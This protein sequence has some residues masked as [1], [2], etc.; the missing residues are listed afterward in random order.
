MISIT[1]LISIMERV[2][3][4]IS[5]GVEEEM[6]HAGSNDKSHETRTIEKLY[7]CLFVCEM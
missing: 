7:V 3:K 2:S 1:L 5:S 6:S 4:N